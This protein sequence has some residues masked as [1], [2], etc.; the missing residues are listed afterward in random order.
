VT[1][2]PVGVFADLATLAPNLATKQATAAPPESLATLEPMVGVLVDLATLAQKPATNQ[3][4]PAPPENLTTTPEPMVGVL[5][6]LGTLAPNPA[7]NKATPT[8]RES[9]VIPLGPVV[10]VIADL[11]TLAL[12]PATNLALPAPRESIATTLEPMFGEER[13]QMIPR[14]AQRRQDQRSRL[15][16]KDG[17]VV[18]SKSTLLIKLRNEWRYLLD[19]TQLLNLCFFSSA[20][21]LT[22]SIL[23]QISMIA[24]TSLDLSVGLV[25]NT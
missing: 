14:K 23:K 10:G 2:A 4:T 24:L 11:V 1:V 16:N 8:P 20:L 9:I 5:V 7:T 12:N 21:S 25:G 19:P 17:L 22:I 15:T 3:A 6:D 13:S 18:L